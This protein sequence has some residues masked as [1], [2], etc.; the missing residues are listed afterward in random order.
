MKYRLFFSLS[1]LLFNCTFANSEFLPKETSLAVG[2]FTV[3][4]IADEN[5]QKSRIATG[6]IWPNENFVVTALHAVAGDEQ[7]T[8][9]Y[10]VSDTEFVAR[11]ATIEKI[12]RKADLALLKIKQPIS[13]KA[14]DISTTG[15]INNPKLWVSGFPNGN[16][17]DWVRPISPSDR[18]PVKLPTAI[19]AEEESQLKNLGFPS[20]DLSIF[21]MVGSL[22]PGDS[23][24]P[25]VDENGSVVAIGNG[26]LKS[27]TYSLGWATPASVL[28]DLLSSNEVHGDIDQASIRLVRSLFSFTRSYRLQKDVMVELDNGDYFNDS[29]ESSTQSEIDNFLAVEQIFNIEECL[30]MS[31]EFTSW[32]KSTESFTGKYSLR[33]NPRGN[34]ITKQVANEICSAPTLAISAALMEQSFDT[35]GKA[36]LELGYHRL[37]TS[38]PRT[39]EVNNCDSSLSIYVSR[40][41]GK[42]EHHTAV[43]GQ[44]KNESNGWQYIK[45]SIP[46]NDAKQMRLAFVYTLQNSDFV[47]PDAKYL[48]D[49]IEIQAR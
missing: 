12:Y 1:L 19:G 44:H 7:V 21:R 3:R 17:N 46:T 18:S 13:R 11:N 14:A 29:F 42:W 24:A 37:S 28:N 6:F 23:G 48:I 15:E 34:P 47:D 25:I 35:N 16:R 5:R 22:V 39:A 20:L 49:D 36:T 40:N 9:E 8:I 45:H 31:A 43:C 33:V 10:E 41:E 38:N 4:V 27:G 26:G 2:Q 32:S 30:P